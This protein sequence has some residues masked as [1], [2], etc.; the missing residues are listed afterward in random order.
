M[1]SLMEPD[2]DSPS[3]T[4]QDAR[5]VLLVVCVFLLL[6]FLYAWLSQGQAVCN[7]TYMNCGET[8]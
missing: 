6:V 1:P 2:K 3:V 8:P 7:Q 4:W 5:A